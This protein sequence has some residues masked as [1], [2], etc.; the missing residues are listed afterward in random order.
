MEKKDFD[1][2]LIAPKGEHDLYFQVLTERLNILWR[3]HLEKK[4][5]DGKEHEK[6]NA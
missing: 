4:E 5:K 1:F 2:D 3:E 6:P